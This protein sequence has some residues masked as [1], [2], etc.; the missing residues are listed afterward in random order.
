MR[1]PSLY[2]CILRDPR[3]GLGE[4]RKG[5]SYFL[6]LGTTLKGKNLIRKPKPVC[7]STKYQWKEEEDCGGRTCVWGGVI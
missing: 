7:G 1:L 2:T 6:T 3:L 4:S 5:L